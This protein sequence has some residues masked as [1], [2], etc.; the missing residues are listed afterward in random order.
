LK[1]LEPEKIPPNETTTKQMHIRNQ[2]NII[3]TEVLIVIQTTITIVLEEV[4]L[5]E[6]LLHLDQAIVHARQVHARQ[7]HARQVQDLQVQEETKY[8]IPSTNLYYESIP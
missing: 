5:I 7:V 3:P 8:L 2:I 4:L 1:I 6:P